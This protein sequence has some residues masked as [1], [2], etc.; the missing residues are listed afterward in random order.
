[1]IH[2]K[3]NFLAGF[4]LLVLIG[5]VSTALSQDLDDLLEESEEEQLE[6]RQIPRDEIPG[7]ALEDVSRVRLP[8]GEEVEKL[9]ISQDREIDPEAYIVGP[10]DLLQLYIWG[11]WD[12]AYPLQVDPEGY[13]LIPTIDALHV[14]N[15]TLAAAKRQIVAAAQEKYP[16][17]P[18]TVTLSSMRFFTVYLTGAVLNEGRVTVHPLTRVSDL[19]EESGGFLD[20]IKGST[21]EETVEGKKIT[22]ARPLSLQPTARRSIE[23]IHRDGSSDD[24]DLPMFQA[25][26]DIRFNPYL[27]MGDVVHVGYRRDE[28]YAYGSVNKT[29]VQEFRPGDTIGTLLKLA[30]GVRGNAPLEIVE[31]W[32]FRG[33]G[34]TTYVINLGDTTRASGII[35]IDDVAQFPLQAKDMLFVRTRADWQLT[36]TAVIYG[37]VKYR[38]HYRV[39]PGHTRLRD[40][41]EKAGGFTENAS[42]IQAKVLRSRTRVQEDPELERL[43]ALQRVT[44]LADMSPEDRAYIKTKGREE[45][46]RLAVDFE[47]LFLE[48]DKTQNLLLEDG[49]VI[50]VPE[51]RRTVTLS[52]QF[53]KPGLI[54]YVKGY[55][56]AYYVERAGGFAWGANEGGARLIRARSGVRERLEGDLLVEAGDEIWVPEKEYRDWWDFTQSTMRTIAETLTL[57]VVVRSF[58]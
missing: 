5:Q 11:E 23:V 44:G 10:G 45:R 58:L 24:I 25:T 1:M 7:Q 6:L 48:N 28:I 3:L 51:L 29:G 4:A 16:N 9:R 46:G 18:I 53:K 32:R 57:V 21:I 52:G 20:E 54:D 36:P 13:I 37:E 19:M 27:K 17:V 26:G 42:L 43:R 55:E 22:R 38:G 40:V 2:W 35:D 50:F 56:V 8:R 34:K 39:I 15:L 31:V 49:D 41:I 33:D 47:R 12:R 14:S 30:G